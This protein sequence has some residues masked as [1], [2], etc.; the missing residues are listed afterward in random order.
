MGRGAIATSEHDSKIYL[1]ADG[2]NN[3]SLFA[4]R[5]DS[6]GTRLWNT[7]DNVIS[8]RQIGY[9]KA[10]TDKQ[11]GVIVVGF[12]QSDFS[13]R[14][15]QCSKYGNLAEVLTSVKELI[16]ARSPGQ[17]NLHQNYP[18]PFNGSSVIWYELSK[19]SHVRLEICNLLGQRIQVLEDGL[20]EPGRYQVTLDA[21]GVASGTYFYRLVTDQ[22]IQT[23]K[24]IIL[25]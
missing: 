21:E 18:N 15:Q 13:V 3:G 24:L 4:Q 16:S 19:R 5:I 1:N 10:V 20:R 17:I 22:G 14:A 6:S 12:D 25:K 8:L 9:L 23:R 7:N 2:R 11:G